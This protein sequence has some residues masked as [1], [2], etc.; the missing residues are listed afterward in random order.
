MED[1]TKQQLILLALLVSF[2]SSIATGIVT[3]SL[4]NQAPPAVTQTINRIIERT[5]ET[6]VPAQ[7]GT[8]T[9][10][11]ETIVVSEDEAVV[12]AIDIA[13]KSIVHIYST[14]SPNDENWQFS[15]LGVV[16]PGDGRIVSKISFDAGF[17]YKIKLHD[18]NEAGLNFVK[19]DDVR[20]MT[21]FSASNLTLLTKAKLADTKLIKLGQKMVVFGGEGSSLIDTG[22]ISNVVREE[23][24]I[25]NIKTNI[26]NPSFATYSVLINL[27][28][29]IVGMKVGTTVEE[30]YLPMSIIEGLAK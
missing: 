12:D 15:G 29:E 30:G 21:V 27:S 4:L 23:D 19:S 9:V 22:I 11:K 5:V 25:T 6:V 24:K 26:I 13:S 14:N 28:G 17:R 2:V 10:T 8:P 16:L 18:N 7:G 20:G 3:V 1:L